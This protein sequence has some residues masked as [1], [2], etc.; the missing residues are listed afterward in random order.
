MGFFLS[1]ASWKAVNNSVLNNHKE[2]V[3]RAAQEIDL[4]FKRPEDVLTTTAAMLGSMRFDP[5]RQETILVELALTHPVFMGVTCFDLSGNQIAGSNLGKLS[6]W[7]HDKNTM[8]RLLQGNADISELKFKDGRTPYI[9][10]TVPVKSKSG[11]GSVVVADINLKSLWDIVDT[12]RL[13]R[14]GRVFLVSKDGVLIAHPDKK[15]VIKNENFKGEKDVSDVLSGNTGAVEL[16]D[17]EGTMWVSSYTPIGAT[18]WSVVLRQEQKEAYEFFRIMKIQSWIVILLSEILAVLSSLVMARV[19]ANPIKALISRIKNT[20]NGGLE[21]KIRVKRYDEIGELNQVL[22]E[23]TE[24]LHKARTSA[25]FSSIGE[26]SVWVAHELKNSLVPIKSF[27]QLLSIKH[28]DGNFIDKFSNVVPE[29]IE[30]CER[31]LKELSDFSLF[32]ELKMSD[33][34]IKDIM[35]DVLKIMEDKLSGR[36][37]KIEFCAGNDD[38]HG[39]VDPERLKRVLL[40]LIINAADAMPAGGILNVSMDVV[41]PVYPKTTPCVEIRIGDNGIG[42]PAERLKHIFE[43]FR[44]TKKGGLG[45]GLAISRRI[46]EQHG[47]NIQ[48]ESHPDNGTVFTISLP[49]IPLNQ[50]NENNIEYHV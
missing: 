26:T 45:L 49:K 43:P 1:N 4:F 33:A 37:I 13:G 24:E 31:L 44:T 29:E 19:F 5:W 9:T 46:I 36:D 34:D 23:L 32:Y 8:S 41:N 47:G 12:I 25:R 38:F 17:K 42:I 10:M 7:P 18:G 14:T 2:I 20:V 6:I 3:I 39:K 35:S 21:E 15:R 16:R 30:R 28:K 50:R 22:N 11:I 48:V 40:N 27:V